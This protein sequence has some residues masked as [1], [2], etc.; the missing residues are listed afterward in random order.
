MRFTDTPEEATFRTEVRE[1][2]QKEYSPSATGEAATSAYQAAAQGKAAMDSYKAWMKKLSTRGWVAP[3]WPKYGGA[4][5]SVMEQ[6]IFNEE[7]ALARAPRPG[8]IGIAMA[9]PTIIAY[10]T[11]EQKQEHIPGML[12]GEA[13]WCQGFSEP[14]SGSDLASLR[15]APSATATTTSSTARRSGP[16]APSTPTA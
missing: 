8:G 2:I 11:E 15:R 10:G 14:E 9:G 16:P 3:A 7:L 12:S 5:M 13:T 1:F 4:G 6:F